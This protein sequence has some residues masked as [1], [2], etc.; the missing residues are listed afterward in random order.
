MIEDI[1]DRIKNRKKD[2]HKYDSGNLLV[3]GGSWRYSGSPVFNSLAGYRSGVDI[4]ST[5]APGR[6]ADIAATFSPS[7]ITVPLDGDFVSPKHFDSLLDL[8]SESDAMVIGG[9]IGTKKETKNVVNRLIEKSDLPLV[10]DADAIRAVSHRPGVLDSNC[11]VT[12]HLA[13][14]RDLVGMDPS[15]DAVIEASTELGCVMLLKGKEDIITDGDEVYRNTTGNEYM[16]VGGTGDTLA[17]IAG[18]LL[19]QGIEPIKAA[20]GAAWINGRAGEMAAEEKGVGLTPDDIVE[21][22]PDAI[23]QG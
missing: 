17:G 22:I 23:H 13:E 19:A 8:S 5:A 20:Y 11:V 10:V 12:P 3:V 2:S 9:G 7:L 15:E 6:A 16:T 1:L 21:M 14:F 4:V 18:S